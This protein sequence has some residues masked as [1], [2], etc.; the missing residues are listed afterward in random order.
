VQSTV[1]QN[2]VNVIVLY[3]TTEVKQ[4][5]LI[6]PKDFQLKFPLYSTWGRQQG[7]VWVV[8]GM[9]MIEEGTGEK[10][11]PR[12]FHPQYLNLASKENPGGV[13]PANDSLES[14]HGVYI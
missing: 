9:I 4:N 8:R 14:W 2:T 10:P 6:T 7:R 13:E 12:T 3:I 5:V 11:V 1:N